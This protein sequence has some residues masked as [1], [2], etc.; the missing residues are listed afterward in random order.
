MPSSTLTTRGRATIPKA[1]REHLRL[2]AGQRLDFRID[3]H[4]RL[5]V[6]P[7]A[8]DIRELKGILRFDR[9]RPVSV[10]EMNE[11]IAEGCSMR[12]SIGRE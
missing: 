8:R 6:I 2:R 3:R 12:C 11:A 1:I 10:E 4:G 9:R 5:V 7:R